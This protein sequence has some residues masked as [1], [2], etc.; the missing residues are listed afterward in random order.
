MLDEKKTKQQRKEGGVQ[1]QTLT[2]SARVV[3]A[4]P[5]S[6]LIEGW[7]EGRRGFLASLTR[8]I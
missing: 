3:N 8:V 1:R 2:G 4:G 6:V 7:Y 5:A